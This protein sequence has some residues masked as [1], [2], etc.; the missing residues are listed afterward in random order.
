LKDT[1]AGGR[2]E[3]PYRELAARLGLSEGAVK[4]AA[5]RLRQRYRDLL[6]EEIAST[7]AGPGEVEEELKHLFAALSA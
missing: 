7:V 1:L 2:S 4:V 5:H 6:R 3:I